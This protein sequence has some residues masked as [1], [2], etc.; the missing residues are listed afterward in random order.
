MSG[1]RK[2]IFRPLF[3]LLGFLFLWWFGPPVFR[4]FTTVSFT[5][6]HAPISLITSASENLR[7]YWGIST[8]SKH[9]LIEAGR[10]QSRLLASY[11]LARQQNISLSEEITRLQ[12]LWN[13]PQQA[14]FVP[15]LAPVV[16]RNA[17]SWNNNIIILGGED[18]D[19][20]VGSPVVF[21]GGIVGRIITV[22]LYT[23]TVELISSPSFRMVASIEGDP[24]PCT[25]QGRKNSSFAT[26]TGLAKDIPTDIT[27]PQDR[28]IRI[29]SSS[30]GG[31]FP[32]GLTI[33]YIKS[34]RQDSQGLFQ[35]GSVQLDKRLLSLRE[36]AVLQRIQPE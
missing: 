35:D 4:T 26:P 24:R 9:E 17:N 21:A 11:E 27:S 1:R 13:I 19:F 8:K 22:G 30:L 20:E 28:P 3:Y 16:R 10:D 7:S 33:G 5:E 25:Y 32:D 23:S 2:T 29:V 6:F 31:V 18:K 36:V 14:G 12:N 15:T 34:L